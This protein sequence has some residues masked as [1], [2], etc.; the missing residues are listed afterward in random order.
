MTPSTYA[1]SR[2]AAYWIPLTII[3]AF[4]ILQALTL[5][6]GTRINNSPFIQDYRITSD[7]VQGSA[8]DR[9]AVIDLGGD[10]SETLDRSM[11]RF[12]LYSIEADEI[13]VIIALARIRPSQLQ[14]DPHLYQYGGAFLYPL[15]VYYAAL[16]KL[17]VLFIGSF[18]QM[19]ANPQAI[20]SVWI[21]GRFFVLLAT[22]AAGV[23]LY[24]TLAEFAPPLVAEA[25]LAI[26]L[27]SPA[28]IM[29]SQV[30][31]PHWYALIF[32]NLVL[33]IMARTIIRRRLTGAGETVLAIAVGLAV[34][35]VPTLALFAIMAWGALLFLFWR[36]DIRVGVLFRVPAIALAAC[37]IT[38]PYYILDWQA[39]A[40]E[41]IGQAGWFEPGFSARTLLAFLR[42]SV[43][44]GFGVV[45]SLIFAAVL[46]QR[47][48]RPASAGA[49][50]FGLGILIAMIVMAVITA[51]QDTWHSTFR[52]IPFV[53][54]AMITF[55][56]IPPLR[57]RTTIF[58]LVAAGAI[59]QSIPLK[60][61]YFDENSDIHSTRLASAAWIDAHVPPNAAICVSAPDLAPYS[62]PP[63]R[64]DRHKINPPDCKWRV[65]VEG[66]IE[67]A[68]V[69]EN[70]AIVQRF[71]PRLSPSAFP[72]VWEHINPQITVYRKRGA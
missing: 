23:L 72:L 20:D 67:E 11:L 49:R 32:T 2:T 14:F 71:R 57:Y 54:P 15:G 63:F 55:L 30:I 41:R 16:S 3:A 45:L 70:W 62:V 8:L 17:G 12:K 6:Y 68:P 46:I 66:N 58:V 50:L 7:V 38:N 25:G 44:S 53:L 47:Y 51:K 65:K 22:A 31:K 28:T 40:A 60:L 48:M 27:F 29:L 61:A 42:N 9:Q 4:V 33:L 18:E 13:A 52:Y 39:V 5:D 19:L 64:F 59:V 26:F 21:A 69:G 34:G 35:S 1:R 43:L 36:G 37:I 56:A 10:R 24:L